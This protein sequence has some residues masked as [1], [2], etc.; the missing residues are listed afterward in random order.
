MHDAE[1]SELHRFPERMHLVP[2]RL[3]K[4][5]MIEST[6]VPAHVRQHRY[7][8]IQDRLPVHKKLQAIV[9]EM[10]KPEPEPEG[11]LGKPYRRAGDVAEQAVG[12]G[13]IVFVALPPTAEREGLLTRDILMGMNG[14]FLVN[15]GR[16]G[17]V[18]APLSP[19]HQVGRPAGM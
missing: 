7:E 17:I 6:R 3:V 19:R 4:I 5:R 14:K 2:G 9:V 12:D 18:G 10:G 15:V 11:D 16:G 13:V 1:E 8:I